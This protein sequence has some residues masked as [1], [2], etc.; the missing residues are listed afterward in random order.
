MDKLDLLSDYRPV[1][2]QELYSQAIQQAVW[3]GQS[4]V[5]DPKSIQVIIAEKFLLSIIQAAWLAVLLQDPVSNGAT[6]PVL[7]I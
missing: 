2:M 7:L 3:R 5:E 4:A 6:L 1:I